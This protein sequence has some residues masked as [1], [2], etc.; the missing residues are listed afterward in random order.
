ML[1]SCLCST[2]ASAVSCRQGLGVFGMSG[3]GR[4]S[5]KGAEELAAEVASPTPAVLAAAGPALE[6]VAAPSATPVLDAAAS[7]G[8]D[9]GYDGYDEYGDDFLTA[10]AAPVAALD[11]LSGPTEPRLHGVAHVAAAGK[12]A[13]G[14]GYGAHVGGAGGHDV[15]ENVRASHRGKPKN[16]AGKPV[17]YRTRYVED[18]AERAGF[19]LGAVDGL[20]RGADGSAFDTTGSRCGVPG[21]DKG[22]GGL[23]IDGSEIYV[24]DGD[25]MYTADPDKEARGVHEYQRGESPDVMELMHHSSMLA[26]AEVDGAGTIAAKDGYLKMLTNHSGHYRPG[27]DNLLG[28]LQSM[29]DRG[30]EVGTAKAG[31]AGGAG[32]TDM[33]HAGHFL[34]SGG[35]EDVM[36]GGDA[37]REQ[38]LATVPRFGDDG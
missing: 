7:L 26:G 35:D 14:A 21:L 36:R 38:L 29:A 8:A 20:L 11:P 13:V 24:Q 6:A 25:H 33:W 17:P 23:G 3:R 2:S 19:E 10:A 37:M 9:D 32:V 16:A 12:C 5:S 22:K 15:A 18:P 27:K 28:T 34:A 30:V 1:P 4:R 31:L